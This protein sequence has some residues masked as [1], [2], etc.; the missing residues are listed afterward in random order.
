MRLFLFLAGALLCTAASAANISANQ[1]IAQDVVA[2]PESPIKPALHADGLEESA[3]FGPDASDGTPDLE[4]GGF[5]TGADK[6]L[7]P[8]EEN[9]AGAKARRPA[10]RGMGF[11]LAG[12]ILLGVGVALTIAGRRVNQ[13]RTAGDPAANSSLQMSVQVLEKLGVTSAS[14]LSI[15]YILAGL[16]ELLR[17]R[18]SKSSSAINTTTGAQTDAQQRPALR[19]GLL[20]SLAV[21]SLLASLSAEGLDLSMLQWG[22]LTTLFTQYGLQAYLGLFAAG[23]YELLSSALAAHKYD[24]T[25]QQQQQ[26]QQ[27]GEE[28]AASSSEAQAPSQAQNESPQTEQET[29]ASRGVNE[30]LG[31]LD[32]AEEA[33]EIASL[34]ASTPSNAAAIAESFNSK[35]SDSLAPER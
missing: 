31:P 35:P 5:E 29:G 15:G 13:T 9:A 25:Q 22:E 16:I 24:K 17:S 6:R 7:L 23:G 32:A 12:L 4:V 19:G 34:T 30:P 8:G 26:Q 33:A 3:A 28:A 2:L 1:A 20:L 18:L 11:L 21:G 27:N 14:K 10:F